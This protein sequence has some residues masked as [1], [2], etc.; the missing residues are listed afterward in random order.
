MSYEIYPCGCPV[1]PGQAECEIKE[2]HATIADFNLGGLPGESGLPG[3]P[4]DPA[5][6]EAY[7]FAETPD[8]EPINPSS[9][10]PRPRRHWHLH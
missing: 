1:V 3:L 5:I 9:F 6:L 10:E 2:P 8:D 7:L 4:A